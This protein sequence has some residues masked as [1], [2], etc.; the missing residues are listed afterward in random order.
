MELAVGFFEIGDGEMQIAFGGR[1]R[2]VA[3]QL[4]HVPEIGVV[5]DHVR[6]AT[7]PPDVRCDAFGQA[8]GLP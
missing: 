4:L 5:P 8:R 7:V 3:E 2:P 1:E 6:G